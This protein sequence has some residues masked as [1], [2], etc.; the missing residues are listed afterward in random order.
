MPITQHLERALSLKGTSYANEYYHDTDYNGWRSTN[1]KFTVEKDEDGIMN[2]FTK[3]EEKYLNPLTSYSYKKLC[4]ENGEV[5]Y[6]MP[7]PNKPN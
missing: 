1:Y 7:L 2:C 3:L 6:W 5:K 4:V